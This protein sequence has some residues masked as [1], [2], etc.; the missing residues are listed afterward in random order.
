M[1]L[2]LMITFAVC[3]YWGHLSTQPCLA[4]EEQPFGPDFPKLDSDATGQWWQADKPRLMVERDQVLAF[5]VYTHDRGVL[6]LT[7]QLYPLL[8]DEPR[9]VRLE[10][11][12]GDQWKPVASETVHELGWSAHFRIENWDSSRNVP[13]RLLHGERAQFHGLIRRDPI[14]KEVIVVGSLS[15]NSSRTPGP[16]PRMIDNLKRQDPD[17]AFLCR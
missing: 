1:R 10:L 4:I 6:K 12:D 5:A 9:V 16:R 11:R 3:T 15:C 8:P 13:Y 2:L 17:L 7:A 14:D